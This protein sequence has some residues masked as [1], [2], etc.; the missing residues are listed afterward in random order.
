MHSEWRKGLL[1]G[2]AV[3]TDLGYTTWGEMAS[4]GEE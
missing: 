4:L 3:N 2:M 1:S